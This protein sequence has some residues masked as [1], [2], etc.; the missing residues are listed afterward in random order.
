MKL[1]SLELFGFKS[2]AD[3]T[4]FDMDQS[5]TTVVGPNGCGKSNTID[6][7]K[8]VLG[9]QSA[10]SL[11]GREMMDVIFNGTDR[12]PAAGMAEVTLYFDN[13]DGTLP[14]EETD[15]A[16]SRRLYRSGES[17]YLINGS[18]CRLKDVRELFMGTGLGPGG[19]GFMEQGK[20]DSVL[21][22]NPTERRR[23]F[24]EAAG[25]SRFRARRHEAELKLDKVGANLLRLADIIS[26]LERQER[27]LKLQ[28]GKARNYK[29]LQGKVRELQAQVALHHFHRNDTLSAGLGAELE[30]QTAGRQ[31]VVDAR[32]QSRKDADAAESE[33]RK[34]SDGLARVRE[35]AAELNAAEAAAKEMV[36]FQEQHLETLD[37]QASGRSEEIT[38]L[39]V[40]VHR[41]SQ[42][43][44]EAS[45]KVGEVEIEA[46]RLADE[47][48]RIE[49]AV[50]SLSSQWQTAESSFSEANNAL[51]QLREEQSRSEQGRSR[52]ETSQRHWAERE[53]EAAVHLEKLNEELGGAEAELARQRGEL[54]I[55]K[56]QSQE[57]HAS[58]EKAKGALDQLLEEKQT[59]DTRRRELDR[60]WS[61]MKTRREVLQSHVDR[62]EGL[63]EGVRAVLQHHDKDP[64]FLPGCQGILL[65]LMTV[66]RSSASLVEGALG[67]L[68]QAVVVETTD[69]A[70]EGC[71]FMKEHGKGRVTFCVLEAFGESK[72]TLPQ[73]VSAG[74]DRVCRVLGNL[75]G[76]WA[77]VSPT[78]MQA[79][80]ESGSMDGVVVSTDGETVRDGRLFATQPGGGDA[81]LVAV[82]SELIELGE[83][84][85][86]TAQ[87]LETINTEL[88]RLES[89]EAAV[90]QEV[91]DATEHCLKSDGNVARGEQELD[92]YSAQLARLEKER[93][94][95]QA[96]RDQ[97]LS[98]IK[99]LADEAA[100]ETEQL[101][102]FQ[103]TM[104][105]ADE[106]FGAADV[107]RID[108]KSR[109]D[110]AT[111]HRESLRLQAVT[112][113]QQ[114]HS[115][116]SN[117]RHLQDRHEKAK[118]T[119]ERYTSELE[120]F[121]DDRKE[122]LRRLEEA[123]GRSEG[124]ESTSQ[125]IQA[126]IDDWTG[127]VEGVQEQHQRAVQVQRQLE[128][129]Y[130]KA[131]E[132]VHGLEMRLNE[133]RVNQENL[134]DHI[135][136]DLELELSELHEDYAPED[137]DWE[138]IESNLEALRDRLRRIGNVNLSAIDDL[139]MVQERLEF[140]LAQRGDLHH[141]RQQLSQILEDIEKESTR[142][143]ME[144]FNSVREHFKLTFRQ[145]FGGGT[146]DIS[147]VDEENILE[148]GIE[149]V[150]R[151]PGSK[152][153]TIT[154]LSGGQRTMTAVALLFSII[155]AHPCPI[156]LLDEVDAALDEDNTERFCSMLG[157]FVDNTQFLLI[158]HS[159]RTMAMADVLFGVTMAER[160]VSR[161][162]GVRFE[163]LDE[164]GNIQGAANE[165]RPSEAA[166]RGGRGREAAIQNAAQDPAPSG[167]GRMSDRDHPMKGAS[168]VVVEIN[169]AA[170]SDADGGAAAPPATVA[171][172]EVPSRSS[173]ILETDA[174]TDA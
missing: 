117:V 81:G 173:S 37:R 141:S 69:E 92:V 100:A 4:V 101:T 84:V 58:L 136:E 168:E 135:R 50:A 88:S 91:S 85:E 118:S 106:K 42:D 129:A 77:V 121:A 59:T 126:E 139:A 165:E 78:E 112:A 96:V 15:V 41:T 7:V 57:S 61:R 14:R 31:E 22:S 170:A 10:R 90:S 19:Y 164:K 75:M 152:L 174:S 27:S 35:R 71:R 104:T 119:I 65:D 134:V 51:Q 73:G 5:M 56:G 97:A 47:L 154:L 171:D 38:E 94:R 87:Q 23:V 54:E 62:G 157:E 105:E 45:D 20:I 9:E 142:L 64:S 113:E 49:E 13:E 17:E 67:E 158:T 123:R 102:L 162:V 18:N 11:R 114:L 12:R 43:K 52:R 26:E 68:L 155:R 156:C 29:E 24:E 120:G 60:E 39:S 144:T 127:K 163:D 3:R 63:A 36:V 55:Q 160:G 145:L 108:L 172:V 6:A 166:T 153:Q 93:A 151:P 74:D 70:L 128:L 130:E 150:A 140:L 2:F 115:Q 149:I 21:A 53:G 32:D 95:Q 66:E 83:S 161:H 132:S 110:M 89:H 25:I 16:V 1:K 133:V 138:A 33:F 125:S 48:A 122:S 107:S 98:E 124:F 109:L 34:M 86:K 82:R 143:F 111:A 147:L 44:A 8:W 79:R 40:D 169:E 28:A 116:R 80:I 159:R 137:V 148:S 131:A 146:A 76:G 30:E 167:T 99:A 46:K 72:S 103:E